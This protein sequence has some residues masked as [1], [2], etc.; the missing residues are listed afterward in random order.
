M[1][2]TMDA[3]FTTVPRG[4]IGITDGRIR[5]ITRDADSPQGETVVEAQGK[6][7]MPGL[8]NTHT[9][10]AMTL[11]RGL[12]EDVPLK[13]WLEEV[14]W[15]KEAKLSPEDVRCGALLGCA[16][17]ISSG[18]TCFNDQ[19]FFM[20]QVAKTVKLSGIRGV[21]AEGM[22]ESTSEDPKALL[23][24]GV[25]FA[26]RYN[27]YADGRVRTML[28][29]HSEYSCSPEFL[30]EV[31]AASKES[32]LPIHMHLGESKELAREV[33]KK[34]G[35]TPVRLMDIVGI[36][37]PN[38]IAAHCIHV[39]AQ[40]IELLARRGVKV[41]YNPVSNMK[42][43]LGAA[44][45]ISM[46]RA[47]VTVGVGTDGA[48]SNN[49]LD[50]LKD[51]KF[52]SYL[53]KLHMNDPTVLP[54]RDLLRMATTDGAKALGLENKIG[55]IEKGKLADIILLDLTQPH[56]TPLHDPYATVAYSALGS[57]V[58]TVIVDG[59]ILMEGRVIKS[60]D[61]IAVGEEA[62]ERAAALLA[63]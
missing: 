10:L 17:L 12:A 6:L 62:S 14:I 45:I 40:E 2:L 53:Q 47:G 19:Y 58:D 21:L 42:L 38:L 13:S 49:R 22:V 57:D 11:F 24:K 4:S 5:E 23:K 33:H 44:P 35:L 48:A 59:R 31:A 50:L 3:N 52:A 25:D 34:Y 29:P 61:A 28:G 18:C 8:V 39:D 16:E 36:L 46:L 20:D 55:S 63:R 7:A 27:G 1:I 26:K 60:V 54:A 9:H 37:G 43:A 51:V 32:G 15:P 41:S 56:M 30:R